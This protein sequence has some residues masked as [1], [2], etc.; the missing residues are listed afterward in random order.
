MP[1]SV[2]V[3]DAVYVHVCLIVLTPTA[4]HKVEAALLYQLQQAFAFTGIVLLRLQPQIDVKYF[5][6]TQYGIGCRY[7]Y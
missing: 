4:V 7:Q 2:L 1:K 3:D 6:L 5:G